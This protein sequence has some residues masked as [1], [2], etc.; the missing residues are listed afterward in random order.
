MGKGKYYNSE[1]KNNNILR[2]INDEVFN[3][4]HKSSNKTNK[5]NNVIINNNNNNRNE[6]L[7]HLLRE[8]LYEDKKEYDDINNNKKMKQKTN[9]IYDE[10]LYSI[11]LSIGKNKLNT[12][13][14]ICIQKVA[15]HLNDYDINDINDFFITFTFALPIKS[16]L[17]YH[18]SKYKT[19][20]DNTIMLISILDNNDVYKLHYLVLNENVTCNGI[21]NVFKTI[22]DTIVK[23]SGNDEWLLL[24][25]GN[26]T[27]YEYIPIRQLS[28]VSS[29]IDVNTFVFIAPYLTN[30]ITM[31]LHDVFN[32]IKLPSKKKIVNSFIDDIN[33]SSIDKEARLIIR[34]DVNTILLLISKNFIKLEKLEITYC[35]WLEISTL[36][37]F[38]NLLLSDGKNK[39]NTINIEGCNIYNDNYDI[40]E[41]KINSL[42]QLYKDI[43]IELNIKH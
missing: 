29:P 8:R 11:E 20:N 17:L 41:P 19:I 18:G 23:E 43:N 31:K 3:Y 16:L 1:G 22:I 12:L 34:G 42:I 26:L 36:Q 4:L 37:V 9:D 14:H 7:S 13:S 21:Q 30:I 35:H 5:A 6:L 40:M 15:K 32:S 10:L 38:Y 27:I 28:L 2:K 39:L 24:L 25:E 33:D